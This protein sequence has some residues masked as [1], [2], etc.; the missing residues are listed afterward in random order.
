MHIVSKLQ[1]LKATAFFGQKKRTKKRQHSWQCMCKLIPSQFPLAAA[2]FQ[3]TLPT[4]HSAFFFFCW[5]VVLSPGALLF[6]P[7]VF[8]VWKL[9]GAPCCRSPSV[10][11]PLYKFVQKLSLY[12]Y[13]F[14]L[15]SFAYS[16]HPEM[17]GVLFS[18]S[19]CL[20]AVTMNFWAQLYK[21]FGE[22]KPF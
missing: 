14:P 15:I 19:F 5:L 11:S 12:S 22:L 3:V 20:R 16:T 7:F 9:E 13:I 10:W 17:P 1:A 2:T 18:W 21:P 6:V 4:L 8:P